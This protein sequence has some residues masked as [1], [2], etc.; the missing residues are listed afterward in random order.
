M[1]KVILFYVSVFII[2]FLTVFIIPHI[3]LDLPRKA[4]RLKILHDSKRISLLFI[5]SQ[6]NQDIHRPDQG[7]DDIYQSLRIYR[8]KKGF[9]EEFLIDPWKRPYLLILKKSQLHICTLGEDGKKGGADMNSDFCVNKP[10]G[11]PQWMR[12]K[13]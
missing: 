11:W 9:A 4:Y 10:N 3:D 6:K 2:L 7:P 5:E 12:Q 13:K 8:E 1:I